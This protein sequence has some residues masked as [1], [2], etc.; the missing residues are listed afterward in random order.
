ME[1]KNCCIRDS[2]IYTC[3][4]GR[5]TADLALSVK[6]KPGEFPTSEE[7]QRQQAG[8]KHEQRVD[9]GIADTVHASRDELNVFEHD[10]QSHEQRP[11]KPRRASTK[12][13]KVIVVS[14]TSSLN[15]LN[16]AYDY[17]TS[18]PNSDD[19]VREQKLT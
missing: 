1:I 11:D 8:Y 19:Q 3:I 9:F 18:T 7:I 14:K 5:S 16:N 6:P 17:Q 10:E 2:G 15:G 4:A 12:R 13:P